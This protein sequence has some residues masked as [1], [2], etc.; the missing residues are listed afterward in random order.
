MA[1]SSTRPP[2]MSLPGASGVTHPRVHPPAVRGPAHRRPGLCEP[3]RLRAGRH[4]RPAGLADLR[5]YQC[6]HRRPW[7]GA[8]PPGAAR[9]R[10]G[11]QGRLLVPL[12]PSGRPGHRPGSGLPGTRA[13]SPNTRGARMTGTRPP[14]ACA[15]S[16]R[17]PASRSPGHTR[18]CSVTPMS[19]PCL[20]LAP[21]CV[22]YRSAARHADPRTTMRL[23]RARTSLEPTTSWPPTWPPAPDPAPSPAA[24]AAEDARLTI[25]NC[26]SYWRGVRSSRGLARKPSRRPGWYCIRRSR[27]LTSAVSWPMSCLTRLAS[28][29]CKLDQA[30]STGSSSG[31]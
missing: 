24:H 27:V 9:V 19:R 12:P 7:R 16:P 6:G 5:S 4:A 17:P 21:T 13:G 2:S 18:T 20:T 1:S 31:A 11:H 15:T 29:R 26:G 3:V 23:R 8:R 28:D 10:Q 22:T 14:A 25:F 30:G